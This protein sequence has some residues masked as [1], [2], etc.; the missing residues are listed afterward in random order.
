MPPRRRAGKRGIDD[1]AAVRPAEAQRRYEGT[2][3]DRRRRR[4]RRAQRA[5]AV[6]PRPADSLQSSASTAV[7]GNRIAVRTVEMTRPPMITRAI[8]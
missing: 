2:A 6:T 8:E 4:G 7:A 1:R 3:L 5:A